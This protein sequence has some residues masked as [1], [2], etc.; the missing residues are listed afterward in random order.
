MSTPQAAPASTPAKVFDLYQILNLSKDATHKQIKDAYT[1]L[2]RAFHPDKQNSAAARAVPDDHF[3]AIKRAYITLSD[4]VSRQAY[5]SYGE[6]GLQLLR[7]SKGAANELSVHAAD[8]RQFRAV[9]DDIVKLKRLRLIEAGTDNN[10]SVEVTTSLI[11]VLLGHRA[12][13]QLKAVS[14]SQSCDCPITRSTT[15]TLSAYGNMALGLGAGGM[16]ASLT[17]SLKNN[18]DISANVRVGESAKFSLGASRSLSRSTRAACRWFFSP[19]RGADMRFNTSH[20][21]DAKRTTMAFCSV[22]CGTSAPGI[23]MSVNKSYPQAKLESASLELSMDT[24]DIHAKVSGNYEIDAKHSASARFKVGSR[25]TEL[26][27]SSARALSKFTRF[28][29]GFRLNLATGVSWVLKFRRGKM[30][31]QFPV[32]VSLALDPWVLL[33]S[34]TGPVLLDEAVQTLL[35][36]GVSKEDKEEELKEDELLALSAKGRKD[37][38]AQ[39]VLMTRV[40]G[41]R[42]R[43]EE[44]KGEEGLV[45]LKALYGFS[46]GFSVNSGDDGGNDSADAPLDVTTPLQFFTREDGTVSL[47]SGSKNSMLGFYHL[48]ADERNTS[49]SGS[50]KSRRRGILERV[51][52]EFQD[53]DGGEEER[54]DKYG[55]MRSHLR[56]RGGEEDVKLLVRYSWHGKT[57]ETVFG[58]DEEVTLP[59]GRAVELG[60]AGIVT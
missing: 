47:P 50:R 3:Q 16:G 15:L 33:L 22:N 7:D 40:A 29:V 35:N 34:V 9:L 49:G 57:W 55:L 41:R 30:S 38:L 12:F 8:P 1:S 60:V 59:S 14:F 13:P 45:V 56:G 54:D 58:D 4:P 11:P 26:Q 32:M 37:A 25:G 48:G 2:A 39:Q 18:S 17:K 36:F 52:E 46:T 19:G 10:A 6:A 42:V 20:F 43:E 27:V 44:E 28:A 23:T 31:F 21:F 53:D 24:N 5:D 51:L